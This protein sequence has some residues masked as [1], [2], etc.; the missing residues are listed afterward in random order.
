MQF[1]KMFPASPIIAYKRAQ[2]LRDLL[3]KAEC[4][5]REGEGEQNTPPP[6]MQLDEIDHEM[7]NILQELESD[8]N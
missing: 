6:V 1:E 3:V 5:V 4:K 8:N 7:I 2:N